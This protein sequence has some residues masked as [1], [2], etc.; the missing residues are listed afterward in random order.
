[1]WSAEHLEISGL[2]VNISYNHAFLQHA[3]IAEKNAFGEIIENEGA[4]IFLKN[5]S[6]Q[7]LRIPN[8]WS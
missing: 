8:I 5:I 3:P 1:M 4:P 6:L 7:W 2:H